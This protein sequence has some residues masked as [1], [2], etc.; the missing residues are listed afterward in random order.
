MKLEV[1]KKYKV[2]SR[3]DIKYIEIVYIDEELDRHPV[4]GK[5]VF[6]EGPAFLQ[7]WTLEGWYINKETTSCKDIV[8]E[9]REP[10]EPVATRTVQLLTYLV[11][12]EASEEVTIYTTSFTIEELEENHMV[13]VLEVLTVKTYTY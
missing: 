3:E 2:G 1:G 13:K 7:T 11:R 4:V 10:I 8:A 5:T 9:Y 12:D 6:K